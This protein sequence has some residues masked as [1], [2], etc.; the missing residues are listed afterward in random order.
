MFMQMGMTPCRLRQ[1]IAPPLSQILSS[2]EFDYDTSIAAS[3]PGSGNTI[4]NLIAA[5]ASGATQAAYALTKGGTGNF[6]FVGTPDVPGSYINITGDASCRFQIASNTTFLTNLHKTTGGQDFWLAIA[7]RFQ[8]NDA[9]QYFM[10][11]MNAS[12]SIGHEL[13]SASTENCTLRQGDGATGT[14]VGMGN[15]TLVDNTDYLFIASHSHTANQSRFWLNT[16]TKT[17]SAHTFA[18]TTSAPSLNWAICSGANS[19]SPMPADSRLYGAYGG[20][21]YIDNAEA[22][23]IFDAINARHGRTYA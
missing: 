23:K 10:G 3:Y 7:F 2:A 14:N 21:A 20:N 5:P 8:Q 15:G 9:N 17:E 6:T 16:R 4:S 11:T 19:G 12:T 13:N 1:G 22:I 18:T